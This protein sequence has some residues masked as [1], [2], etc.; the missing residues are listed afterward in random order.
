MAAMLDLIRA[1]G[2]A[3]R[4]VRLGGGGANSSVWRR[5]QADVYGLPVD[6]LNSAEGS[7]LGA[8]LLAGVGIGVWPSVPAACDAA[9]RVTSRLEPDAERA[10][11][12]RRVR[13][14]YE[15][16]YPALAGMF[17]SLRAL[18]TA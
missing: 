2:V 10:G 1:A 9:L 17:P 11:R 8:A 14:V 12:Y 6:M 18:E 4:E 7:A 15:A 16:M 13:A 5:I 3:P